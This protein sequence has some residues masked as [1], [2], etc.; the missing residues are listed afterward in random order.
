METRASKMQTTV[1]LSDIF[2][3][4]GHIMEILNKNSVRTSRLQKL[5]E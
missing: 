4:Q 3:N 2:V 5:L 1:D